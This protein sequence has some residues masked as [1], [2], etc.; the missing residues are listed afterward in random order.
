MD[1]P[2]KTARFELTVLPHLDAAYN[3]A[4]WLLRDD[5]Q[6]QDAAQEACLR[7]FQFFD[8]FR[9]GNARAWLLA[10]VRNTCYTALARTR[11]DG[12]TC[13]FDEALHSA[14]DPYGV[15]AGDLDPLASL[16]RADA[17]NQVQRCLAELPLE[18]REV[19]ILREMEGFSYKEI[20]QVIDIPMGT[21]MSRLSRAR[22]ALQAM[23]LRDRDKEAQ[24][25]L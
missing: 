10:V 22:D 20:G 7:A 19:L 23:L 11:R 3:L 24:R 4:R 21:V 13:S 15:E 12:D 8:S 14:A 1:E 9:G 25:E 2:Y 5:A 18:Y 6:A 16:L 17:R